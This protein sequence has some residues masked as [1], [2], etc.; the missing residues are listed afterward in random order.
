MRTM[1]LGERAGFCSFSVVVGL[2]YETPRSAGKTRTG[3][4]G[5]EA[6]REL[7]KADTN[8]GGCG[9]GSQHVRL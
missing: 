7:W 1:C 5:R 8:P 4:A 9:L 6:L 3:P 2:D